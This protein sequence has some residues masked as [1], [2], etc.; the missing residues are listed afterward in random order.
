MSDETKLP[1]AIRMQAE[2]ARQI[3]EQL[4]APA[5]APA[6][7]P[8]P[9]HTAAAPAPAE[10]SAPAPADEVAKLREEN[11]RLQQRART[12]DGMLQA[13]MRQ[14]REQ[15]AT[16]SATVTR[17]NEQLQ[18]A[19]A[20]LDKKASE[21]VALDQ[22]DIE[23]FGSELVEMVRRQADAIVRQTAQ[24]QLGDVVKRI[25]DLESAIGGVR[26]E[27][28][29]TAEQQFI[30]DMDVAVPNWRAVNEDPKFIAWL[31]EVDPVYGVARQ[32]ALHRAHAQLDGPRAGKI[33]QTYLATLPAPKPSAPD[34]LQAQVS[35]S[36]TGAADAPATAD[37]R[38]YRMTDYEQLQQ[39]IDRALRR[40][41]HAE[42][43]R[44]Q[45]Q[46]AEF[47]KALAEGRLMR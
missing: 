33:F 22:K 45:A 7:E 24:E 18:T 35:P 11:A 26:Q 43:A 3:E 42:V 47:D 44:L 27:V 8:A 10:P 34:G 20:A 15:M 4:A 6:P 19:Q 9:E 39:Q 25:T 1:R 36:K 12:A 29:V 28:A 23:A 30:R 21:G 13:E 40:G 37:K 32:Q 41:D 17:L 5:E 31:A 38:M 16:Q 46:E 2:Q 14:L